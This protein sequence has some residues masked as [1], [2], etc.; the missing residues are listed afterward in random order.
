M[1]I[2]FRAAAAALAVAV[3]ALVLAPSV[4]AQAVEGRWRGTI[5]MTTSGTRTY[6]QHY[7]GTSVPEQTWGSSRHSLQWRLRLDA[8]GSY[9]AAASQVSWSLDENRA[10]NA[11]FES[12][13]W[14]GDASGGGDDG[15]GN[16]CTYTASGTFSAP[17]TGDVQVEPAWLQRPRITGE[18]AGRPSVSRST[19]CQ[20]TWTIGFRE[21]D[22]FDRLLLFEPPDPERLLGQTTLCSYEHD[23]GAE[24]VAPAVRI[25]EGRPTLKVTGQAGC[26]GRHLYWF[27]DSDLPQDDVITI[28]YSY[29]LVLEPVCDPGE[30]SSVRV[31]KAVAFGCFEPTGNATYQTTTAAQVGGVD[32]V[33][34]PTITVDARSGRLGGQATVSVGGVVLP[35]APANLPTIHDTWNLTLSAANS[36][37]KGLPISGSL[38]G[39]WIEGGEGLEASTSV[40]VEKLASRSGLDAV[41]SGTYASR[42]GGSFTFRAR[43]GAGVDLR[44]AEVRIGE[45]SL[46]PQAWTKFSRRISL[47]DVKLAYRDDDGAH[48]WSGAATLALPVYRSGTPVTVAG[49]LTV[50]DGGLAGGGATVNNLNIPGPFGV[51]VQ[52]GEVDLRFRPA[53]GLRLAGL[54]SFGPRIFSKALLDGSLALGF[55]ELVNAACK[56]ADGSIDALVKQ[57]VSET[58]PFE[59]ELSGGACVDEERL[60]LDVFAQG[61]LS[62]PLGFGAEGKA[63]GWISGLTG[64]FELAGSSKIRLPGVPDLSGERIVSDRGIAA[65]GKVSWLSGGF[66]YR[67]GDGAPDAFRGCDLSPWGSAAARAAQVGSVFTVAGSPAFVAFRITRGGGA[68]RVRVSGPGGVVHES[69]IDPAQTRFDDRVL[70][71]PITGKGRTFVV[72]RTPAAGVWQVE[73]LDAAGPVTIERADPLPPVR[74]TGRVMRTGKR[75]VLR[76]TATAPP[77]QELVFVE[78]GA[79]IA[80]RLGSSRSRAGALRFRPAVSTSRARRVVAQVVQDGLPR[81]TVTVARFTAPAPPRA[82]RPRKLTARVRGGA[83]TVRFAG[84]G[85]AK[86]WLLTLR[87][88]PR[89]LDL[90]LARRSVRVQRL[91]WRPTSVSV[92][93]IGPGGRRSPAARIRV[94]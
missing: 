39:K 40:D 81:S 52:G 42:P 75:H 34:K 53:L 51:Y 49:R 58:L 84:G 17:I 56:G 11:T 41:V 71:A 38:T 30:V 13:A 7:R 55:G 12:F 4:S 61:K 90:L 85:G 29:D 35:L 37:L 63:D 88:G 83:V 44:A 50:R 79:G 86:R 68:P 28:S 8:P 89:T 36:A 31:G 25:V 24:N 94:R 62:F 57:G 26:S 67:W 19:G 74:V 60:A 2:P 45:V 15:Q 64:G 16:A 48:E 46:L 6:G 70:I 82:T 21:P 47:K 77:G 69:P 59:L 20:R 78:R 23:F 32:L 1:S 5:D 72:V 54:G 93:G 27:G 9:D 18:A 3:V 22:P 66:G 43:N 80:R 10:S 73:A 65:C 87:R 76:W 14:S 33:P 92:A 91:G